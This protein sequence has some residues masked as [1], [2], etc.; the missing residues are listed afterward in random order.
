MNTKG[1]TRRLDALQR[2]AGR[3]KPCHMTVAF[4]DGHQITTAP[5]GDLAGIC[6]SQ[7]EDIALITADRPKYRAAAAIWTIICRPVPNRRITDFE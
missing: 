1:I 3:S 7:G 5:G 6:L 4:K 2:V